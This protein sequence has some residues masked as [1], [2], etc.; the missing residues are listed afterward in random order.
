MNCFWTTISRIGDIVTIIAGTISLFF[1]PDFVH[2]FKSK[3]YSFREN[4]I[5]DIKKH[6]E[7]FE[8]LEPTA[9]TVLINLRENDGKTREG[10]Y[11]T[12]TK[13]KLFDLRKFNLAVELLQ[14]KYFIRISF[15]KELYLTR[16][17][18]KI[19]LT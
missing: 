3:F 8:G 15:T 10:L 9:K 13:D 19:D 2:F 6:Q 7:E 14:S 18:K 12:L 1:I 17:A 4:Y 5:I 16:K 11:S